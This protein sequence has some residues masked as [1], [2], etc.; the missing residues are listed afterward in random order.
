LSP[1]MVSRPRNVGRFSRLFWWPRCTQLNAVRLAS[2]GQLSWW[3]RCG[4]GEG[5][6]GEVAQVAGLM[7]T[8]MCRVAATL[9]ARD[10]ALMEKG[11]PA[12]ARTLSPSARYCKGRAGVIALGGGGAATRLP[13]PPCRRRGRGT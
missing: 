7:G 4:I 10:A 3:L 8:G 12:S 11:A 1:A 9:S 5:G 6:A 2:L 13:A